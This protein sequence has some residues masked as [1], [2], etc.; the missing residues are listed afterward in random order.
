MAACLLAAGLLALSGCASTITGSGNGSGAPVVSSAPPATQPP[1]SPAPTAPTTR[2]PT[3][4]SSGGCSAA[5]CDDFSSPSSG[6]DTGNERHFFSQYSDYQGGTLRMGERHDAV[7]TVPAPYVITKAAADDSVQVDVELVPAADSTRHAIYGVS[8]WN[9]SA[10]N[11]ETSAFLFYVTRGGAQIVLWDNAD[12]TAH[13]LKHKSWTGV[14][15]PRPSRNAMRV[16]CLQR[17]V[18][19]RPVAELG[20]AVNGHV[21]TTVYSKSAKHHDWRTGNHVALVVG[22]NRSDV[23]YDNFTITG[24]CKGSGC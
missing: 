5:F 21:L 24:E 23:F 17:T 6:W 18:R 20:M 13:V 2:P 12:G 19:G 10:H 3:T 15:R 8:C 4:P 11:G 16:L 14:L 1:S 9:H 22:L 7:L